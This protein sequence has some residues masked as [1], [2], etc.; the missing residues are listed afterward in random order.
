MWGK[1]NITIL[2]FAFCILVLAGMTILP[3]TL[4]DTLKPI[5]LSDWVTQTTFAPVLL[6]PEPKDAPLKIGP[7]YSERLNFVEMVYINYGEL[8][9][10]G[11]THNLWQSDSFTPF[12]TN[13]V[14]GMKYYDAARADVTTSERTVRFANQSVTVEIRRNTQRPNS[15]VTLFE[16]GGTSVVHNWKNTTEEEALALIEEGLRVITPEEQAIIE[17]F[18]QLH[19]TIN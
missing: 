16:I 1:K 11:A 13:G 2:V 18:D 6:L 3:N 9:Q 12:F 4:S 14:G 15:G 5:S 7:L 10:V 19:Q 17:E 8:N